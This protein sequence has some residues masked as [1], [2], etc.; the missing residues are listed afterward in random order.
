MQLSPGEQSI[1]A[2]FPSSTKASEAAEALKA[3]GI[4]EVQVDR[5]SRYGATRDREINNPIAGQAGTLTGLTLFSAD[6]DRFADNDARILMAADP[7]VSGMAAENHGRAEGRAFLLTVVAPA[8]RIDEAVQL[9]T[10][11]NAY[12]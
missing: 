4:N 3:I 12:F 10:E 9:L 8:E 5:I 6:T 7:S 2:Y 1:L 11:R